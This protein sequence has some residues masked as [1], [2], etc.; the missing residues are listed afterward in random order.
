MRVPAI[1]GIID[2]R[3]LINYRVDPEVLAKVC[4]SPFRPQLVNGHG[5]AGICLIRLKEIRPRLFPGW[6]GISSEN[7]AHRIAVEWDTPEGIQTGVYIPRRDTSSLLNSL[8]GGRLFPGVHHR[9]K[10]GV[11]E[12]DKN[13]E[14]RM[15]SLDDTTK[16]EVKAQIA[17]DLP[18]NSIFS[19]LTD[20]ST[21][22]EEGSLGYS[23]AH[24]ES[25]YDGLR[26][27]TFNWEVTPL[28]VS[29]VESSYFSDLE[30]FPS[31]SLTFDNALLMQGIDHEWKS[32]ESI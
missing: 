13:F 29:H 22:F 9:A 1:R 4:P 15:Q 12:D 31:G 11:K 5:V 26:L 21:F 30:H 25:Q 10:F 14:L 24:A 7:A 18:E 20:C 17:D 2:R 3:L 27:K 32:C 28:T 19:S 16:V 6:M 23:P 8:A